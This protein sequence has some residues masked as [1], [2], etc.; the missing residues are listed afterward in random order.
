MASPGPDL[1]VGLLDWRNRAPV[2]IME[3]DHMSRKP[4][5]L[6]LQE[7]KDVLDRYNTAVLGRTAT[8]KKGWFQI[9]NNGQTT[10]FPA[11]IYRYYDFLKLI[12]DLEG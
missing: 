9:R 1:S 12:A 10:D 2:E 4:R 5:A 7:I 6:S 3:A 11:D 8:Y